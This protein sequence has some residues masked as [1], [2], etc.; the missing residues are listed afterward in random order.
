MPET[1]SIQKAS[2]TMNEPIAAVV[3]S[4]EARKSRW[5][6]HCCDF[7]TFQMLAAISRSLHK[8]RIAFY[9][10]ARWH[11]KTVNKAPEEPRLPISVFVRDQTWYKKVAARR[12]EFF[13]GMPKYV[14]TTAYKVYPKTFVDHDIPEI[15]RA[16]RVPHASP[17]PRLSPEVEAKICNVYNRMHQLGDAPAAADIGT[18]C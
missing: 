16:A 11:R 7:R 14:A 9:R 10:W 5:G 4:D 15:Y 8:E 2:P 1:T 17:V 13:L 18:G 3:V 12:K 6:Y